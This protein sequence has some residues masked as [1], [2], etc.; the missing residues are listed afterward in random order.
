MRP[1]LKA[2]IGI[3]VL[4]VVAGSYFLLHG[5]EAKREIKLQRAAMT[6][7]KS[8]RTKVVTS[9]SPYY[10]GYD[11]EA[12]CPDRVHLILHSDRPTAFAD[13]TEYIKFGTVSYTKV[14]TGEWT[15]ANGAFSI[16]DPCLNATNDPTARSSASDALEDRAHGTKGDWR[17]VNADT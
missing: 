13:G 17:S 3:V 1:S 4:L 11:G 2:V 12:V 7:A 14:P 6:A 5:R 10:S 15:F 16:P 9:S 8:F